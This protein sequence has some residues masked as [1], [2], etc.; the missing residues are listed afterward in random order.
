MDEDDFDEG[1]LAALDQVEA[2]HLRQCEEPPKQKRRLH[3]IPA[4][5]IVV[6]PAPP[7]Q[8]AA[9]GS[10]A[11]GRHRAAAT[12]EAQWQSTSSGSNFINR[13]QLV[14]HTAER[15]HSAQQQGG[16]VLPAAGDARH[17]VVLEAG[18]VARLREHQREGVRWVYHALAAGQQQPAAGSSSMLWDGQAAGSDC[19]GAV[20]AD[21]MGLGKTV[22]SLMVIYALLQAGLVGGGRGTKALLLCPSSLTAQWASEAKKWLN[23]DYRRRLPLLLATSGASGRKSLHAMQDWCARIA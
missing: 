20:L 16:L 13:T 1:F 22:Q 18:L 17:D 9:G 12:H 11:P 8:P 19:F 10:L 14:A 5:S 3:A 21:S 23:E 2:D 7:L 4:G 15:L 6:A